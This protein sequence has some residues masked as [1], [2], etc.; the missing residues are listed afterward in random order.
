MSH[1]THSRAA[2]LPT[3]PASPGGTLNGTQGCLPAG[4]LFPDA[5]MEKQEN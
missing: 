5:G 2:G 3:T 1:N 4:R